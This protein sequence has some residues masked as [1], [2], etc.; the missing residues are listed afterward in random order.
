MHILCIFAYNYQN[1]AALLLVFISY[2]RFL[3]VCVLDNCRCTAA[4]QCACIRYGMQHAC[5]HICKYTC[6]YAHPHA[7][8]LPNINQMCICI[9][10]THEHCFVAG[11]GIWH[12][13]APLV[14]ARLRMCVYA[15]Y[16]P[17]IHT[18][19]KRTNAS[20]TDWFLN[21]YTIYR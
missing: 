7:Y 19:V 9:H 21:P 20:G 4:A 8:I 16:H 12:T 17:H 1:T 11:H 2:F 13:S 10:P 6:I 14:H 18:I 5:M 15:Q 3:I